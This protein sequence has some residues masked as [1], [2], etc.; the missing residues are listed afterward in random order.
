MQFNLVAEHSFQ[1]ILIRVWQL[2]TRDLTRVLDFE[3]TPGLILP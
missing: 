1:T 3:L 2:D